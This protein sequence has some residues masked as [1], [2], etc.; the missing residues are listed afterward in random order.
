L[1]IRIF[2]RE[3]PAAAKRNKKSG[4][5][6]KDAFRRRGQGI[7]IPLFFLTHS[8]TIR[9]PCPPLLKGASKNFLAFHFSVSQSEKFLRNSSKDKRKGGFKAEN[10]R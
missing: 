5:C 8:R 10:G 2:R 6:L 7:L 3:S 9:I 4:K 1:G